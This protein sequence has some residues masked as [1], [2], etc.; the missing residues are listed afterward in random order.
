MRACI[1]LGNPI[2]A[3]K[4]AAAG[5]ALGVSVD[6]AT[7]M[8]SELGVSI[9]TLVI[10]WVQRHPSQPLPILGSRRIEVARDAMAACS[11]RLDAQQWWRIWTAAAGHEVA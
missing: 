7:A 4:G 6:L 8:A 10:A 3:R 5:Q 2:L 9:T 11:L 1:N